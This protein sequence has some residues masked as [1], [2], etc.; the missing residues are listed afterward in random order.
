M[1][2]SS[3]Q[4]QKWKRKIK[5][6]LYPMEINIPIYSNI[7]AS[8]SQYIPT[9]SFKSCSSPRSW[10]A[11]ETSQKVMGTLGEHEQVGL[12]W[13]GSCYCAPLKDTQ[14]TVVLDY[15]TLVEGSFHI[16]VVLER[17][18][19][20]VLPVLPKSAK[21]EVYGRHWQSYLLHLFGCFQE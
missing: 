8:T 12:G 9:R 2:Q 16:D 18:S 4:L 6:I 20:S 7:L 19:R 11:S 3:Q 13:V 15:T 1:R 10:E 17:I 21:Y 5:L 14:I